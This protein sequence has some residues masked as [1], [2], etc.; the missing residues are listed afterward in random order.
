MV[1]DTSNS[2]FFIKYKPLSHSF[3]CRFVGFH[4]NKSCEVIYGPVDP[5]GQLCTLDNQITLM[6]NSENM[7]SNTVNVLIPAVLTQQLYCFTAIGRTPMFTIAVE[8]TFTTG[9]L[10]ILGM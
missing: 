2:L 7:V 9:M 3:S 4:E 5:T 10:V 1:V 6:I 8:G